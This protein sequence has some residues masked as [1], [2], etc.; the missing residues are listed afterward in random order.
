VRGNTVN[1]IRILLSALLAAV[2]I[3][4]VAG[5]GGTNHAASTDPS[6]PAAAPPS[7]PPAA[8]FTVAC[9]MG[10]WN[11]YA[12]SSGKFTPSLQNAPVGYRDGNL[13]VPDFA[14]AIQNNTRELLQTGTWTVVFFTAQGEAAERSAVVTP[15]PLPVAG[16]VH[17]LG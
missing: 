13:T 14:L 4:L 10:W 6:S 5:C 11:P 16:P 1:K 12:G 8:P 7:S 2:A 3:I 17:S 15:R 9:L